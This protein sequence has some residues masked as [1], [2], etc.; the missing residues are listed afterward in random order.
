M[1]DECKIAF[2][3]PVM[4]NALGILRNQSNKANFR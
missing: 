1:K 3:F 2:I 4:L